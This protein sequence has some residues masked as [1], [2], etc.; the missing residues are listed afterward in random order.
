MAVAILPLE[1]S[2]AAIS[3][4]LRFKI[5]LSCS[6]LV[7]RCFS[8]HRQS[9]HSSSV[10]SFHGLGWYSSSAESVASARLT[11]LLSSLG[12]PVLPATFMVPSQDQVSYFAVLPS[13][14]VRQ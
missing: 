12:S 8:C 5:N 14:F 2:I 6:A 10:A 4:W 3:S 11:D 1:A 7:T 9:S 13:P